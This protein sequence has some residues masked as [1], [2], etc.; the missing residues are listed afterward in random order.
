LR[1]LEGAEAFSLRTHAK[2]KPATSENGNFWLCLTF[3]LG[4]RAFLS[5]HPSKGFL[6]SKR[7]SSL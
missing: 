1:F 7:R 6:K 4:S 3:K 5:A 2:S